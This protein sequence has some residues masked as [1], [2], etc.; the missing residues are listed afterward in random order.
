[1]LTEL[2]WG[3]ASYG[4]WG[5]S[6]DRSCSGG[7]FASCL[8]GRIR[9]LSWA[10]IGSLCGINAVNLYTQVCLETRRI[11]LR[12]LPRTHG[13]TI[14]RPFCWSVGK[15]GWI[16]CFP[17]KYVPLYYRATRET[18]WSFI[19]GVRCHHC[20]PVL[21]LDSG[22]AQTWFACPAL[23]R[24]LSIADCSDY[25]AST[26]SAREWLKPREYGSSL[27]RALE[28]YQ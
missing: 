3:I 15:E 18:L 12:Y 9:Q 26:N 10:V 4:K 8:P 2:W 19:P 25:L 20:G 21:W 6:T 24:H 28:A 1:M 22:D 17:A 14:K 5:E 13:H 7:G 16:L 27:V 23:P 11:L